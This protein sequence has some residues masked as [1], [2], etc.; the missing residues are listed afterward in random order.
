MIS[1]IDGDSNPTNQALDGSGEEA[2]YWEDFVLRG[3]RYWE[4]VYRHCSVPRVPVQGNY[5]MARDVIPRCVYW[6]I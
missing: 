5:Q 4:W 6:D 1:Y 2:S 3:G